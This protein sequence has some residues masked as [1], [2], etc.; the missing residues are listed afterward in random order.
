MTIE[1]TPRIAEYDHMLE[2]SMREFERGVMRLVEQAFEAARAS[3]GAACKMPFTG[4]RY[5]RD[6][7]ER[8]LQQEVRA[9]CARHW[10]GFEAPRWAQPLPLSEKD[11]TA[12]SNSCNQR[13]RLLAGYGLLL[14]SHRWHLDNKPRLQFEVFC[15]EQ[16]M[17]G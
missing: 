17:P 14:R 15:A 13:D 12:G 4:E 10:H 7:H 6:Q 5:E 9:L 2:I 11:C 3:A 1:K 16:L 8:L